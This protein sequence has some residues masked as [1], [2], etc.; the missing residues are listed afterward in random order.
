MLRRQA[1][2]NKILK[3]LEIRGDLL[4]AVQIACLLVS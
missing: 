2:T 4:L 3:V 1:K